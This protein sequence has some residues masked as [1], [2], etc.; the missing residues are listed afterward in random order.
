[1]KTGTAAGSSR[2]THHVSMGLLDFIL[3]LVG[4][5][6]W[7]NWRAQ[8]RDAMRLA[9]PAT[10]VGTLRRAD[11]PRL[12]GWQFPVIL[13]ALLVC[14]ALVYWQ[15]GPAVN[16][17]GKLEL[18][19]ISVPFRSDYLWRMLL[20]SGLS[21]AV[22]FWVFL[23]WLLL[24]S[25]LQPRSNEVSPFQNFIRANLGLVDSWPRG[26]KLALPFF[27]TAVSWWGLS[28]LFVRLGIV[29]PPVSAAHRFEQA[30]VIGLGSYLTW[31]Y[32][33]AGV[34]GLHLL[35]S[36]IYFG[37][38]PFWSYVTAIAQQML[39]PVRALPLR[40]SR[41]DFAPLVLMVAVLFVAETLEQGMNLTSQRRLP[42]LRDLYLKLPL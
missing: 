25:L 15:I 33:I 3:N 9:P 24:L 10:L 18:G 40:Y 41:I 13:A 42:G 38:H 29:L 31:K 27:V 6:L 20:F 26:A 30:G 14:R 32:V 35:N 34:M 28:W 2:T 5:L 21:F 23:L 16:W 11:K 36:Y 17:T 22:A 12:Y 19:V 7:V 8:P 39:R 1:L 4:L 37:R